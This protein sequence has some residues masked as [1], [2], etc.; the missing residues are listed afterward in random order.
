MAQCRTCEAPVIWADTQSGRKM[1]I[2]EQPTAKGNMVYVGGV[3]RTA[4]AEDRRLGR[5]LYTSHF[6][7]CP[8]ADAHRRAR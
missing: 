5:P 6:A 2:D 4:S 1:P 7:T 3:A 8:D